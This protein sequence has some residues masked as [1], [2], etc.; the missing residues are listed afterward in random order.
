MEGSIDARLKARRFFSAVVS[1]VKIE[2]LLVYARL[3]IGLGGG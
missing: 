3:K 2:A 1:A